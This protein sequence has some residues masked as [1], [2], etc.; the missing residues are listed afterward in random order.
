MARQENRLNKSDEIQKVK[1]A[2]EIVA[3]VSSYVPSLRQVGAS[4]KAPCPFHDD[5][6][7]SFA[8]DPKGQNYRCWACGKFGDV[9]TFVQEIERISFSEG[10]DLLAQR[11]RISGN[12]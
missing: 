9:I 6:H 11:A 7:P 12:S 2:S 10:L 5:K 4:F 8:V 1:A 3:V